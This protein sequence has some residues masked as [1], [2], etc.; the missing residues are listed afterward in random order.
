MEEVRS[1][2]IISIDFTL[3]Y[4]NRG[5]MREDEQI[6]R[7]HRYTVPKIAKSA[8]VFHYKGRYKGYY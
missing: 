8:C 2:L 1:T 7:I 3:F 4:N 6:H 5:E